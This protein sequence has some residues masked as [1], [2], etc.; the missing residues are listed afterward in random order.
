[1]NDSDLCNL[2]DFSDFSDLEYKPSDSDID[3]DEN[4]PS[5]HIK[6]K[7]KIISDRGQQ[8]LASSPVSKDVNTTL[9]LSKTISPVVKCNPNTSVTPEKPKY[10]KKSRVKPEIKAAWKTEDR[11]RKRNRGQAYQYSVKGNKNLIRKVEARKIGP[12]CTCKKDCF[13]ILGQ[14]AVNAIFHD[15]WDLGDYNLQNSDLQKKWLKKISN[16]GGQKNL[17]LLDLVLTSILLPTKMSNM[18]Y[19]GVLFYPYMPLKKIEL[20]LL[21][22]KRVIQKLLI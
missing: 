22:K 16:E 11:K 13:G 15:F 5:E 19:A 20:Y 9:E 4:N 18:I 2:S 21:L 17:R 1:M 10:T 6:N 3:S 7:G 8:P 12:P 14:E